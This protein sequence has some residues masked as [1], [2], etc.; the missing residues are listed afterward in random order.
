MGGV[1]FFNDEIVEKAGNSMFD[2]DIIKE[3]KNMR[4]IDINEK[5]PPRIRRNPKAVYFI[6][7]GTAIKIGKSED[8]L[9][10]VKK[11]QT[12]NPRQLTLLGYSYYLEE[13]YTHHMFIHKHIRGEWYDLTERDI[14]FLLKKIDTLDKLEI[15]QHNLID[16]GDRYIRPKTYN[17]IVDL[18]TNEM[19]AVKDE[20][21]KTI[22]DKQE[23]VDDG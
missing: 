4:E 6:D 11:I 17:T 10:R 2:L 12:N 18:I 13:S 9:S 15:L 7:D 19:Q 22:E 1:D 16:L 3:K 20:V 14:E 5:F 8:P 23:A 21:K